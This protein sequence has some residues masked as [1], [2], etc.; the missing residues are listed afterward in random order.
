MITR[1]EIDG[2]KTFEKFSLDLQPFTAIV[3]PNASGKSNLFDAIQMLSALAQSDIRTAMQN[4]RGEPV[5]LFRFTPPDRRATTM[6]FAI[7]ATLEAKGEDAFGQNYEVTNSRIAYEVEL[8]LQLDEVG[9]PLGVVVSRES[10][11]PIPKAQDRLPKE[12]KQNLRYGRKASFI[13]TEFDE[14][15]SAVA[16]KLRQ[17]G[18]R[19]RGRP[20]QFSLKDAQRTALSTVTTAEFPHVY[21]LK[22]LL[23]SIHFLQIDPQA[24]RRPSDRLAGRELRADAANLATVIARLKTETASADAPDGVLADIAADLASLI[25]SVRK[26]A[27]HDETKSREY[28]FDLV[29]ADDLRFSSRVIS[30]GT[31]RLLALLTLLNDPRRRGVLC[32]E[33]PENG[34]HE[35]RIPKLIEFLRAATTHAADMPADRIFQILINTHSPAVMAALENEE[36]VA[37]DI[38]SQIEPQRPR[39]QRTRMRTGVSDTADLLDPE[40]TLTRFELNRLLKKSGEAA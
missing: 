18:P 11:E 27:L 25:T 36:I 30:D 15:G 1:I 23:S 17:D 4:L 33:E 3:G 35:G 9:N 5:E 24:A 19:K 34:V 2:F 6:R 14:D 37:A 22:K 38:V 40:R 10:C 31:L 28:G 21:A 20:T 26:I 39:T 13:E 12:W 8:S 32:F 29:F 7:Q 16:L